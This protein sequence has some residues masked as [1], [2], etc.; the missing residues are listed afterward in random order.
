MLTLIVADLKTTI[1]LQLYFLCL[2]NGLKGRSLATLIIIKPLKRER[3]LGTSERCGGHV[4]IGQT[5]ARFVVYLATAISAAVNS[6]PS[7]TSL[8]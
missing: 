7:A 8:M 4:A 1:D 3:V 5:C 6:K 2:S